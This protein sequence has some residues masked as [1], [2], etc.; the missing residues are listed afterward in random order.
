MKDDSI[1]TISGTMIP[2]YGE[3]I[4]T[5]RIIPARYMKALDFNKLGQYAF[6]DERASFQRQGK[7]HPMDDARFNN[8]SILIAGRNFGCGSSREHAVQA[9]L[10]SGIQAVIGESFG[11]IFRGNSVSAG[12]PCFTASA[13]VIQELQSQAEMN[14]QQMVE[15]DVAGGNLSIAGRSFELSMPQGMVNRFISGGWNQLNRLRDAEPEI[16]NVARS[17]P[18]M[19]WGSGLSV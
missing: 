7:T 4:D 11:E 6:V 16:E 18:Y 15:I 3:D 12:M 5:D 9:L 1:K 14:P 10:R 2:V 8:A 19:Q 17:L 13:S